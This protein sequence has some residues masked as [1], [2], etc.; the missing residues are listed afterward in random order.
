[1][2]KLLMCHIERAYILVNILHLLE[3]CWTIYLYNSVNHLFVFPALDK[4]RRCKTM[5]WKTN[6]N[7]PLKE[8][9]SFWENMLESDSGFP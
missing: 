1:M 8:K 4:N 3:Y 6:L 9:V 5:F 7:F 2:M